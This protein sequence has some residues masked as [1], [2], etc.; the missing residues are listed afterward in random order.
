[1]RGEGDAGGER[2]SVGA[3]DAEQVGQVAEWD[4]PGGLHAPS[5]HGH[6]RAH[7]PAHP[8]PRP[9]RPRARPCSPRGP[10]SPPTRPRAELAPPALAPAGRACGGAATRLSGAV[11]R[12]SA[13]QSG[14]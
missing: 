1:M 6:P 2:P 12:E 7:V 8:Q 4:A 13:G 9:A 3:G 11:P 14:P 10:H 5:E